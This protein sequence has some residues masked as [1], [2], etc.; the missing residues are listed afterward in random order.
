ME[1]T[2]TWQ[3]QPLHYFITGKG[4]ALFFLHGFGEDHSIFDQQ[5]EYLQNDFTILAPDIPGTGKSVLTEKKSTA[6]LAGMIKAIID[7]E[8]ISHIHLCGHSMGGYIAMEFARQFPDN[9]SSLTLFHSSAFADDEEKINARKKSIEFLQQHSAEEFLAT[10]TPN[11]FYKKED[12]EKEINQLVK[13]NTCSAETLA[14]YYTA[15]MERNDNSEVLQHISC[16]VLII[17]GE[18]DKA[19]PLQI[20]LKQAHLSSVSFVYVLKE[21]AH[22]GMLEESKRSNEILA[23]FLQETKR[24]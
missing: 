11:L 17:A 9:L 23:Y 3:K 20:N 1:K 10:T 6:A 8:K 19:V 2:I 24:T 12:H 4:P 14:N 7:Q 13:H 5:V 21:S 22:M 15:M 16:P 18:H